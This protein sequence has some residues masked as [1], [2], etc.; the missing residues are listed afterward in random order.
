MAEDIY[1]NGKPKNPPQSPPPPPKPGGDTDQDDDVAPPGNENQDPPVPP[2]P[3]P[4]NPGGKRKATRSELD[5]VAGLLIQ[6]AL[7]EEVEALENAIARARPLTE[8]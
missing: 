4:P 1:R 3:P 5:V 7:P 2:P 8:S 6:V